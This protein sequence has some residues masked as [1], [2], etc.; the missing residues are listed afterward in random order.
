MEHKF[1]IFTDGGC[2]NN[3]GLGAWAFIVLNESDKLIFHKCGKKKITTNNEMELTAIREALNE[4]NDYIINSGD[5]STEIIINSD[6]AYAIG[7]I[8]E[9]GPNWIK[10]N[11]I[12][13]KS[14]WQL[15]ADCI[16]LVISINQFNL[17]KVQ[18]NKVK[19]HAGIRGNELA[20]K[21]LNLCMDDK[22][23]NKDY[24]LE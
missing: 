21:L 3:P 9:W 6:S 12:T 20:D 17:S 1:N 10:Q 24:Q 14:N 4:I 8:T 18:F 22:H 13:Q 23:D 16:R 5:L 7:C 2:R 11:I 19:G 15:V